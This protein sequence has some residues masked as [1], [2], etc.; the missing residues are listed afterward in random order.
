MGYCWK[1]GKTGTFS[2]QERTLPLWKAGRIWET[3][4]GARAVGSR[5]RGGTERRR[6]KSQVPIGTPTFLPRKAVDA[7]EHSEVALDFCIRFHCS[8][9]GTSAG[10]PTIHSFPTPDACIVAFVDVGDL[11][12]NLL[13]GVV[14]DH[15]GSSKG[16]LGDNEHEGKTSR[17]TSALALMCLFFGLYVDCRNYGSGS[18]GVFLLASQ[19]V[20]AHSISKS[21]TDSTSTLDVLPPLNGIAAS[22][23]GSATKKLTSETKIRPQMSQTQIRDRHRLDEVCGSTQTIS[24]SMERWRNLTCHYLGSVCPTSTSYNPQFTQSLCGHSS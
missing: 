3:A 8:I 10:A 16:P 15:Q 6:S 13:W 17:H 19:F 12:S 21:V 24:G 2:L 1:E 11:G 20:P 9:P 14:S 22:I 7:G 5:W 18:Y 4:G 23:Y